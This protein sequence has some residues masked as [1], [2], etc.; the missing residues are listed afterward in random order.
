VLKTGMQTYGNRY[1]QLRTP[2]AERGPK[3]L[4]KRL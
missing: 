1:W 4:E 3:A 2:S